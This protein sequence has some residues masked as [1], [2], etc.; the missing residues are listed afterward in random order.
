MIPLK[1]ALVTGSNPMLSTR[2]IP[3][4]TVSA[5]E[6][7]PLVTIPSLKCLGHQ[8]RNVNVVCHDLPPQ[9]AVDGLLGLGVRCIDAY[10]AVSLLPRIDS[11]AFTSA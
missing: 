9:S 3:L 5:I 10:P 1:A 7:A 11:I 2:R 4:I 8:L 6:Y